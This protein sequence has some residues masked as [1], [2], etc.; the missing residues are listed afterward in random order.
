MLY[1]SW[2]RHYATSQ[3]LTGSRPYDVIGFLNLS[4]PSVLT[5]SLEL[6]HPLTE[7]SLTNFSRE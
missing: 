1:R 2:M 7:M 3:K 4:N 5:M 6:T